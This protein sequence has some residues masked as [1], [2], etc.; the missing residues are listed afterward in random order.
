MDGEEDIE[1]QFRLAVDP[2]QRDKAMALALT[3]RRFP[4]REQA[5]RR[6]LDLGVDFNKPFHVGGEEF[7][8]VFWAV[9]QFQTAD[10]EL[11]MNVVP[12]SA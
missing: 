12:S 4:G 3:P 7:L 11:F 6:L 9:Y 5:L 2:L 10:L 8:P 1:T